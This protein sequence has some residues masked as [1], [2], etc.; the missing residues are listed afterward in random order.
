MIQKKI[1][2]LG[3][4]SVGKT[5]LV[6]QYIEGIFNE[7]YLTTIGV[8]V[9]KKLVDL[10]DQSVQLMLWDIEGND[11]YN[12]FQERYLRGAAGYII[13]VDHTRRSS[14]LEGIDIHTLARQVTSAPA[15]LAINKSDLPKQWHWQETELEQYKDVFDHQF[16]TSAKTGEKVEEMFKA[17]AKLTLKGK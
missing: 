3:A 14:L 16:S 10:D 2:L 1:C 15:I 9:D 4:S 7:K 6:K 12:V 5:S 13:V 11:Q 17:I 8:K